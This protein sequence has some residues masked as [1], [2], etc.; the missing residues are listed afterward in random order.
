MT[1]PHRIYK[2]ARRRPPTP[3]APRSPCFMTLVPPIF[4][5]NGPNLNLLGV[6]E[7]DIYGAASLDD[8]EAACRE[9]AANLGVD[10]R[11]HQTN[12][13]G[14]LVELVHEAAQAHAP[15]VI[16]P[17][18]Y[19]HTS[20]A[21]HDALKIVDAPVVEV[22]I[23]NTAQRESFRARSL[24]SL[25]ATAVISGAGVHSYTLGIEAAWRLAGDNAHRNP[26]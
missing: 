9:R 13:E 18:G 17:A 5:L 14:A 19:G 6:R 12:H 21:L 1:E 23:S 26:S 7:P 24:V 2:S 8:I 11:F 25:A 16:N 15:V 4:V 10:I 20:I 22:H 3:A